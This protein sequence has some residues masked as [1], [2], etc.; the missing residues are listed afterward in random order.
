MNTTTRQHYHNLRTRGFRASFALRAAKTEAEFS[1]AGDLV[2]LRLEPDI[3]ALSTLDYLQQEEFADVR[4]AELA[5]ADRD[6]VWGVIGEYR[7]PLCGRWT[8]AD[9][10]GGFIGD[11]W[12]DSGY[13]TNIKATTLE[14]LAA[15]QST[16][17]A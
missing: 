8:V 4:E 5:R 2:R 14:T 10:C 1:A 9:S 13:D 11:D 16:A 3:D 6:G 17:A 15:V 7:C 12:K